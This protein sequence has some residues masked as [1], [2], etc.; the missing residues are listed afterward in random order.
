MKHTWILLLLLI[1]TLANAEYKFAKDWT[2]TD[3]VWQVT[4]LALSG[5]DWMQTHWAASRDFYWEDHQH[6]ENNPFLGERPSTG[7]VD[8][9]I[10]LGMIAH[11]IVAM[12]LPSKF[13][14]Y[15]S[16]LG[17]VNINFRRIWQCV[18]IGIEGAAVYQNY[19][20]GIRLEF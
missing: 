20:V 18:W 11:T 16:N 1:P 14:V 6:R 9:L 17:T 15:D 2:Y 10:P 8:T 4:F 19:N 12:A 3:T 7:K 13:E 5:V